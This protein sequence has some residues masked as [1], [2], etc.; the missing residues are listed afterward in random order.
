[1]PSAAAAWAGPKLNE[2]MDVTS[3]I[4]SAVGATLK[5]VIDTR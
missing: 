5:S 3:A 4:S 1:M 2:T